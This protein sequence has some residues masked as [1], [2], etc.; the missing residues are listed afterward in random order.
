MAQLL[1]QQ[2]HVGLEE[3]WGERSSSGE[4]SVFVFFFPPTFLFML[5]AI[6]TGRSPHSFPLTMHYTCVQ[7]RLMRD[8]GRKG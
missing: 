6:G 7:G 8:G 4:F 5:G 2:S 1:L 3:F